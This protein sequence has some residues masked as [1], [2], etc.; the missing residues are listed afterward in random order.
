MPLRARWRSVRPGRSVSR[1]PGGEEFSFHVAAQAGAQVW[2]PA[3]LVPGQG[4]G[5]GCRQGAGSEGRLRPP[6]PRHRCAP[7]GT[8]VPT[9]G[10]L[11]TGTCAPGRW[12]A[13]IRMP[14]SMLRAAVPLAG[15][16]L[17]CEAMADWIFQGNPR[18]YDLDAAVAVSREQWWGTPRYRDRMAVGDRIWL[19]VVGPKDPGIYY[20]ATIVSETAASRARTRQCHRTSRRPWPREPHRASSPCHPGTDKAPVTGRFRVQHAPVQVDCAFGTIL[21][22][23]DCAIGSLRHAVDCA[24]GSVPAAQPQ[25]C[26]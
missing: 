18:Y 15:M 17:S 24:T 12:A 23:R 3:L 7:P 14:W 9:D 19:Q 16:N 20:V 8:G 26:R 25:P 22:W 21:T 5:H 4:V 11:A 2:L 6:W 13:S 1:V 10:A